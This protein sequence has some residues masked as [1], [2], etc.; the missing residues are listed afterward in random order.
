MFV[1][2][3]RSVNWGVDARYKVYF[4][5]ERVKIFAYIICILAVPSGVNISQGKARVKRSPDL[6]S[7]PCVYRCT[8]ARVY[9]CRE[10][11]LITR[12]VRC[13]LVVQQAFVCDTLVYIYGEYLQNAGGRPL[14]SVRVPHYY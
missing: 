2:I 3:S 13:K 8:C 4:Y 1:A 10:C 12:Q 14:V 11:P 6:V 7:F 9:Y 5:F